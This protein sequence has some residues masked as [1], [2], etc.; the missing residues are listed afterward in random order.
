M[1]LEPKYVRAP[2]LEFH[3][4]GSAPVTM[5]SLRGKV[6]LIDFWDYTCVNCIRT[7]PYVSEWDRRYRDK[8]LVTIGVHAPE[9]FFARS[10]ANVEEAAA[11]FGISYPVV[12]DNDYQIW[13]AYANRYWPAEYLIDKDG[14]IRYFHAGEGDYDQTE[15][16]IQSLLRELNP[17]AKLPPLMEPVRAM[18]LAGAKAVCERP[19]PELYLGSDRFSGGV[20]LIG[21]WRRLTECIESESGNEPSRLK[22]NYSAAEVNLVIAL[23]GLRRE[24]TLDVL[25]N[26]KPLDHQ[27]RGDDVREE[28]DGWTNVIIDRPRMY[29][30]VKRDRFASRKLELSTNAAGLQ[31]FAFTFVSCVP[32]Q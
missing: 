27:S 22:L 12:L 3:L 18:D 2:E 28:D 16:A 4:I 20:E 5:H 6:V 29:S 15:T 21:P 13:Q 11:R 10:E 1:P 30:L 24:V 19:T 23:A 9:F 32:R 25:D 31:L 14:Y 8:G 26:G 17:E 7:L